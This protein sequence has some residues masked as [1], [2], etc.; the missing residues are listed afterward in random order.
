MTLPPENSNLP[1]RSRRRWWYWLLAAAVLIAAGV[2]AYITMEAKSRRAKQPPPVRSIPVVAAAAKK[3]EMGVYLTGLGSVTPL[4]TVVVRSRVDGQLM[5]VLFREGEIV[6]NGQLLAEIDPRPFQ[7]QLTQAEG[8]MAR[9]QA[10][11]KNARLDLER[12]QTLAAQDSIARQQRDTQEALVRQ[13]EGAIKV[14]Q[15]Q[16]DAARL[17]LTYCR[18][19]SPLAGRVGLRQVDPG[20]IIHAS[21][22]NGLVVITQLEPI[23][24]IFPL[25]EDTL[26]QV[27][28]K[29][30]GNGRLAVEAYDRE[31]KQKLATGTLLTVDNQIDPAT[32]T[33]RFKAVF[34]NGRN[35]LFPNQFVNARLLAEVKHEAVIVPASA[36]QRGPQGAFVY[37]VKA[38]QSATVRPVTVGVTEG[39]DASISAGLNPGELVVI[40]GAERLREGI[41]VEVKG[42][43]G[44]QAGQKG[45]TGPSP[46]GQ[47]GRTG[48][49]K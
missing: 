35:E 14:D 40:D 42:S 9:D 41:K 13:L 43:G 2:Y 15:G 4:N 29:L 25:P 30:K 49:T 46:T 39:G 38:D 31:L 5:R 44:G 34:P 33:V 23:A 16:I 47:T 21:D 20:N 17:Q 48:Q 19:T 12:F 27:M 7:V 36:I 22:A 1:A 45:R 24:V 11:L 6:R 10:Q 8:Q 28:G 18:I 32:G 3:G 37:V 26:P